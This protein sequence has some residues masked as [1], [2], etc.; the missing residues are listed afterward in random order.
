MKEF[1]LVFIA[2]LFL[3][4]CSGY[5]RENFRMEIDKKYALKKWPD[6]A[7]IDTLDR[8]LAKEPIKQQQ[9]QKAEITMSMDNK[10]MSLPKKSELPQRVQKSGAG[11]KKNE[12]G[13]DTQ[14]FPER[15]FYALY[16][17]SENPDNGEFGK[18]Y[19]AKGGESLEDLL[20]RIYGTGAKRVPK[21]VS[22]SMI[23]KLNP[24]ADIT[25]FAEGEMVLLPNVK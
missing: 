3:T 9:K 5:E 14:S 13:K 15:F 18:K 6:K 23:K 1:V 25:S 20:L 8:F 12:D 24:G 11:V 7:Y 22:E 19:R 16:K 10:A 4:S 17:L 2:A 21:H